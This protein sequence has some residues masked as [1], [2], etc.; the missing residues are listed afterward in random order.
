VRIKKVTVSIRAERTKEI[1][2]ADFMSR[3][4]IFQQNRAQLAHILKL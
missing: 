2:E 1:I 4:Q 3:R